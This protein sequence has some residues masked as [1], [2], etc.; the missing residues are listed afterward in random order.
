MFVFGGFDFY[1]P[2]TSVEMLDVASNSFVKL[3]GSMTLAYHYMG[4]VQVDQK[5]LLIGGRQYR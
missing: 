2:K 3:P 1:V 5:V 4:V